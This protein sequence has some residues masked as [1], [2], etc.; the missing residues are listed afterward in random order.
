MVKS[1]HYTVRGATGIL[2]PVTTFV[3]SLLIGKNNYLGNYK[4]LA[5]I[6]FGVMYMLAE[7]VTFSAANMAE[8]GKFNMPQFMMLLG[9]TVDSLIGMATGAAIAAVKKKKSIK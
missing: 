6:I 3:I 9:G 5:A 2:L 4:W 7:Y 8:F 1:Y